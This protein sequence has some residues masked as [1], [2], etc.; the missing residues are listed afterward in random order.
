MATPPEDR[1]YYFYVLYCKDQTLYAGYTI[2]LTA[3]LK[4]HN[5][6]KGAKYTRLAKRRPAHMIYAEQWSTQSQAMAAEY[7]F[8]QLSRPQ[9]EAYLQDQGV[10]CLVGQALVL[11]DCRD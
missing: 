1:T 7:R 8:K 2:D 3:R 6:G 11:C 9:K 10:E 5:E 4:T